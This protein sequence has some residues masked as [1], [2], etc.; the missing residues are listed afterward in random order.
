VRDIVVR[1]G[2]NRSQQQQLHREISGMGYNFHEILE[3]AK[4]LFGK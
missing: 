4:D 1:L 2:L 3:I